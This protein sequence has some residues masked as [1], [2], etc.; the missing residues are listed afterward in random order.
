MN[1]VSWKIEMATHFHD[2]GKINI[3]SEQKQTSLLS[4]QSSIY[5]SYVLIVK[6]ETDEKDV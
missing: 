6:S 2:T 3:N 1:E 4:K 5:V